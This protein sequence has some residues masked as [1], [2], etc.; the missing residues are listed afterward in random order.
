[1]GLFK[2]KEEKE[3]Q[4]IEKLQQR[5]HLDNINKEELAIIKRIVSDL[6]GNGLIKIGIAL[7]FGK[8]EDKIKISYLSALVEQN[9]LLFRKLDE[10]SQKLNK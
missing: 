10:I 2:S 4:E 5:F 7:S 8:A 1:M 9:W 6:T 3:T